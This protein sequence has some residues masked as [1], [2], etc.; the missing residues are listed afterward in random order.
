MKT[1]LIFSVFFAA[2]NAFFFPSDFWSDFTER[3]R[4][5]HNSLRPQWSLRP[6]TPPPSWIPEIDT[7]MDQ[8]MREMFDSLSPEEQAALKNII[9]GQKFPRPLPASTRNLKKIF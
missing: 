4:D 5:F 6:S 7:L 3:M 9:F 8:K 2:T 1:F